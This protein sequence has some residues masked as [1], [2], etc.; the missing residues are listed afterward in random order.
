MRVY[1][2]RSG[3]RPVFG[4]EIESTY[5][6]Q[7]IDMTLYTTGLGI[8]PIRDHAVQISAP[9]LQLQ[10]IHVQGSADMTYAML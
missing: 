10:C 9:F 2:L 5:S 6:R 7:L 3:D 1:I 8:E 4:G